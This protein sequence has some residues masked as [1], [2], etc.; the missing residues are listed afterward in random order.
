MLNINL[1]H[2]SGGNVFI[3]IW[4]LIL[5]EKKECWACFKQKMLVEASEVSFA[6]NEQDLCTRKD[7]VKV[8]WRYNF[9]WQNE[10]NNLNEISLE[11]ANVTYF[12]NG[13]SICRR[14]KC[15]GLGC[16]VLLLADS[17]RQEQNKEYISTDYMSLFDDTNRRPSVITELCYA[18]STLA[19]QAYNAV[20]S[21]T[22]AR[23]KSNFL[24][25]D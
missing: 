23:F 12:D 3:S 21:D 25:S 10:V 8:D 4:Q 13:C 19:E 1:H 7:A 17:E 18:V 15:T 14:R 9:F 11:D 2:C 20:L 24:A 22:V 16:K 6:S 5:A